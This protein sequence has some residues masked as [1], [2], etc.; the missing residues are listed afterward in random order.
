MHFDADKIL[1]WIGLRHIRQGVPHAVAN[2]QNP[3]GIATED[4]LWIQH[5]IGALQAKLRPEAIQRITLSGG[6]AALAQ[7]KAAH[8]AHDLAGF[9]VLILFDEIE[10]GAA[11]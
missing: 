6:E 10:H 3:R 11:R 7:H 9:R 8:L 4:R 2:F 1:V 5:S